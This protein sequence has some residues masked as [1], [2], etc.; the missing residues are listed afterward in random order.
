MPEGPR[1]IALTREY[2]HIPNAQVVK[3][4][5]INITAINDTT[6]YTTPSGKLFV[7]YQLYL[8]NRIGATTAFTALSGANTIGTYEM[9]TNTTQDLWNSGL[10]VL[11]GRAGGEDFIINVSAPNP[12]AL[13]G[14]AAMG[15]VDA[16]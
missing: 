11:I 9:L 10:P 4:E 12:P 5:N 1:D 8:I 7:V 3:I 2:G 14:H 13:M 15:Y 6:I 16:P